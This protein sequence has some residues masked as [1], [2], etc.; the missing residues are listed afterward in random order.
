M[1]RVARQ[2]HL[3]QFDGEEEWTKP[4]MPPSAA[5]FGKNVRYSDAPCQPESRAGIASDVRGRS[6]RRNVGVAAQRQR[7]ALD[8][9]GTEGSGR[10]RAARLSSAGVFRTCRPRRFSSAAWRTLADGA[11]IRTV[12]MVMPRYP[13][14]RNCTALAVSSIWPEFAGRDACNHPSKRR[15]CVKRVDRRPPQ[16]LAGMRLMPSQ[17]S[18][19]LRGNA[20]SDGEFHCGPIVATRDGTSIIAQLK[21]RK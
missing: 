14:K 2:D 20:F 11:I 9:A 13:G 19:D 10:G 12:A 3:T 17:S 1:H 21:R 16:L 4:G 8:S 7:L 5:S 18:P 15:S 6:I